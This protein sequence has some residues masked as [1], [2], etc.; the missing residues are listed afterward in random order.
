M[1]HKQAS[2]LFSFSRLKY[3]VT[4]FQV[5]LKAPSNVFTPNAIDY[6]NATNDNRPIFESYKH[7]I[8]SMFISAESVSYTHLK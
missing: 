8:N 4:G 2:Q 6:G 3:D 7:Y 5:G 1:F